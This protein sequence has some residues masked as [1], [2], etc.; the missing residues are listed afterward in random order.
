MEYRKSKIIQGLDYES[1]VEYLELKYFKRNIENSNAHNSKEESVDF[2]AHS[3]PA[4]A[5]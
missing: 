2:C 5:S 3:A 4:S 1:E